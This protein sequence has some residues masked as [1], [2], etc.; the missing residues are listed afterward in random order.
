M[1]LEDWV[2]RRYP[3]IQDGLVIRFHLI[4][5]FPGNPEIS[6]SR[7]GVMVDLGNMR[8]GTLGVQVIKDLLD[9]ATQ[10]HEDI[11]AHEHRALLTAISRSPIKLENP[12]P[13]PTA[14]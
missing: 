7:N 1:K 11:K 2:A 13:G 3:T 6:A 4:E 8:L 5:D 14:A 9:L 10:V 12:Y